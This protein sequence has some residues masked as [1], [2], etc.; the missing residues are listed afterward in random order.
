MFTESIYSH[1]DVKALQARTDEQMIV[2]DE[3]MMIVKVVSLESVHMARESYALLRQLMLPKPRWR[4]LC[5]ELDL[6]SLIAC[7]ALEL[8]KIEHDL[9]PP[10]QVQEANLE[11]GILE[12]E[13]LLL[14]KNAAMGLLRLGKDVKELGEPLED[15]VIS[16]R[17][18]ELDVALEDTAD[19][20]LKG[21]RNITWLQARVPA[22]LHLV[23]V[24]SA[25]PVHFTW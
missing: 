2:T 12:G 9:L 15:K 23:N 24:L 7:L 11:G 4:W 25:T 22:L 10:L 19:Q 18:E 8:H 6:L 13:A 1:A 14:L 17:A 3:Q 21:T 5:P 20:V 16:D